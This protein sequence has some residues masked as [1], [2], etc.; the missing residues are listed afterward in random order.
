ML[1]LGRY[2]VY[3]SRQ[4]KI[5]H[6]PSPYSYTRIHSCDIPLLLS[7]EIVS[8]KHS[9]VLQQDGEANQ[10]VLITRQSCRS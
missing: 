1:L 6:V 8:I 3:A 5:G 9:L 7:V 10:I 4:C 2:H